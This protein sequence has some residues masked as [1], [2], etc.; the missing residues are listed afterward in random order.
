MDRLI[1]WSALLA[2][3]TEFA[4]AAM[5]LPETGDGARW[6]KAVAPI[7]S[8]QATTMALA[9]LPTLETDEM[10][11]ALD[12]AEIG[13]NAAISTLTELWHDEASPEELL[14]LIEDARLALTQGRTVGLGMR[15]AE[16][17]LVADHPAQA[18]LLAA[19][20]GAT[21]FVPSPG[22]PLF[23]GCPALYL[24]TG[25]IDDDAAELLAAIADLIVREGV[26]QPIEI[27]TH[28]Q[29]YRQFDFARGG[30]VRD[31]VVPI[32]AGMPAGQPLLVPATID[33]E[34][35]PVPLPPRT[36]VRQSPLPIV[37]AGWIGDARDL[38]D[39]T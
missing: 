1:T 24:R 12:R 17:P 38:I 9:E 27:M 23:D 6:R 3:W 34:V 36:P 4:Q 25:Q 21:L 16:G 15:V 33:G 11:V 35:M 14:T 26:L 30:P 2:R 37:E 18:A 20:A 10:P 13:I 32:E 8:L 31:L 7:I 39:Q 28:M 19:E 22:I 29:A 5:S